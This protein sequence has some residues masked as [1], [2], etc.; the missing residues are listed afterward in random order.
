LPKCTPNN[1]PICRD[2]DA[3][4]EIIP[5]VRSGRVAR[6]TLVTF[7]KE[8]PQELG[9]SGLYDALIKSTNAIQNIYYIYNVQGAVK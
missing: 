8:H 4:K 3:T 1:K 5:A 9:P 2:P 6:D 7:M